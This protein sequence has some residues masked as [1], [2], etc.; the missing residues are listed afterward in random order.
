MAM[1]GTKGDRRRMGQATD[2]GHPPSSWP[3][4]GDDEAQTRSDMRQVPDDEERLR[5]TTR[6]LVELEGD[7]DRL[8]FESVT[9]T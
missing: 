6:T 3:G 4:S 9:P 1:T 8:D 2:A 7:S 5:W